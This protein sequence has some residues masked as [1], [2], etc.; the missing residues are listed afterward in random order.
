MKEP[1]R[2]VFLDRGTIKD[3]IDLPAFPFSAEMVSYDRTA[4]EEICARLDG[5]DIAVVNKVRLGTAELSRLPRL[6]MIAVTAT[7]TDNIDIDAC[8]RQDIHVANVPG[9]A[10]HSVPE[11]TFALMLALRRSLIGFREDVANGTWSKSGQ[12]CLHTHPIGDLNAAVLGIVGKGAHGA[13]VGRLAEAF[14]MRVL[15]AERKNAESIRPGYI[16][17]DRVLAESDIITLHCPLTADNRH[18]LSDREFALMAR[19]PLLINVSRGA[20]I[21]EAALSRALETGTIAGAGLDVLSAEPPSPTMPLLDLMKRPN[22]II[23]PHVAW[24]SDTA[25]RELMK[26]V[27]DNIVAFVTAPSF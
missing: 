8:Q 3:G 6:R 12:F 13:A 18:M 1:V 17:F 11:H 9:Y 21:D 2:I 4:P 20:L 14:G 22:V 24:A 25:T 7:G 10:S 5:A 16:H 19:R 15:Y 23:T 27:A 26:R